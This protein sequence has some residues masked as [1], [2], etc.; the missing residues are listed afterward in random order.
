MLKKLGKSASDTEKYLLYAL[1]GLF[2][3]ASLSFLLLAFG[4]GEAWSFGYKI[5]TELE[6]RYLPFGQLHIF[7]EKLDILAENYL[8]FQSFR[9]EDFALNIVAIYWFLI[10]LGIG[11]VI[12]WSVVSGLNRFWYF[13]G[14]GLLVWLFISFDLDALLQVS[15][16]DD[17]GLMVILLLFLPLSYYFQ[18]IKPSIR[19]GWRI[20]AFGFLLLLFLT[21]CYFQ[22]GRTM[23]YA[24]LTAA[25]LPGA[26]I[27]LIAFCCFVGQEIVTFIVW[28]VTA[29]NTP[30]SKNS[31]THFLILFFVY[32]INLVLSYFYYMRRIDWDLL[33]FHP[34]LLFVTSAIIGI[35][36]LKDKCNMMRYAMPFY[37]LGVSFY[38]GMLI[39]S[40]A[41]LGYAYG[42]ANDS[43]I[44]AFEEISLFVHMG[45][46]FMFL[47]YLLINFYTPM[48]YNKLIYK[49]WYKPTR[50]PYLLAMFA[51]LLMTV[52]LVLQ[53]RY[54]PFYKS[55]AGY[56]TAQADAF[57]YDEDLRYA[58][59]Y[60]TLAS[61]YDYRNH[62]SNY[63]LGDIFYDKGDVNEALFLYNH[64]T[65]KRPTP[66]AY[67]KK[68]QM[69]SGKG[70]IFEALFSLKDGINDFPK[71]ATLLNN[72]AMQHYR[73]DSRD[74]AVVFLRQASRGKGVAALAKAN[75]AAIAS[76][77]EVENDE[78]NI[79]FKANLLSQANRSGELWQTEK[80]G[81]WPE[82]ALE[83]SSFAFI[84]N[85]SL[86]IAGNA[87]WLSVALDTLAGHVA[88]TGYAEQLNLLRAHVAFRDFKP[89]TA[90]SQLDRL[91]R[92]GGKKEGY[93]NFV[94]ASWFVQMERPDLATAYAK[95]AA[96][97]KVAGGIELYMYCLGLIGAHDE[98]KALSE[99][100]EAYPLVKGEWM[101]N[102][103]I[104]LHTDEINQE[105]N[106]EILWN[107]LLMYG[108]NY[109]ETEQSHMLDTLDQAQRNLA[110]YALARHYFHK[111]SKRSLAYLTSITDGTNLPDFN[112]RIMALEME[113]VN[114]AVPSLQVESRDIYSWFIVQHRE[115]RSAAL[116]GKDKAAIAQ[117]EQLALNFPYYTAGVLEATSF[118]LQQAE[119][120]KAYNVLVEALKIDE[121][122]TEL[123]QNYIIA[124]N[125]LGM[126]SYAEESMERLKTLLPTTLYRQFEQEIEEE[127]RRHNRGW[128]N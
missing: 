37:P 92:A 120:E 90:I 3:I 21:G 65:E 42:V 57:Y 108:G 99:N 47:A 10:L 19:L 63:I 64:A 75:M 97:W 33:Y 58:E 82:D 107:H 54:Y 117:Y 32:F 40:F 121:N 68:Q 81:Y 71:S 98:A 79:V 72:M 13:A 39:I 96:S 61:R 88:G 95:A 69:L 41:V 9:A 26:W 7:Q 103:L 114:T 6:A 126:G 84:N 44:D 27:M 119:E 104:A 16:M 122:Q 112:A 101:Q 102:W 66:Y 29:R 1:L 80:P 86:N 52:G 105:M 17:A 38:A 59:E 93:F 12:L 50:L 11:L 8:I 34:L 76:G 53:G 118:L 49:I 91:R 5:N 89:V 25:A 115:A 60:Y 35:F 36:L 127:K 23:A 77:I 113:H 111:D 56:Y 116:D 87:P 109:T 78:G 124:S 46:G 2:A 55:L 14:T 106:D 22:N 30:S 70:Q 62:R 128:D 85:L 73:A 43:L 51:G 31:L 125:R 123:L 94:L 67:L 100:L 45:F 28:L 24:Q 48:Y 20:L 18:Y 74:S 110:N 4:Y 83:I 15:F